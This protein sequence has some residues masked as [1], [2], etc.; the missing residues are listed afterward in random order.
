MPPDVVPM[1]LCVIITQ[2]KA[3][4]NSIS[5]GEPGTQPLTL[6]Y[7]SGFQEMIIAVLN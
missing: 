4:L 3:P 1:H 5:H 7:V 2:K 6:Q